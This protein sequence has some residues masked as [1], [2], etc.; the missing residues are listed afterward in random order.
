MSRSLSRFVLGIALV[1]P[2]L[3]FA[4]DPDPAWPSRP[5][6]II[7]PGDAGGVLDIRGRAGWPN[8]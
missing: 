5:V 1:L 3:C 7:T 2:T 6:T 4:A 8:A